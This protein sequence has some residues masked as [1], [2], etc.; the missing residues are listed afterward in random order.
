MKKVISL[1]LLLSILGGFLSN[2]TLIVRADETTKS[3]DGA[4]LKNAAI[5]T[6]LEDIDSFLL[7]YEN[8]ADNFDYYAFMGNYYS[9]SVKDFIFNDMDKVQVAEN[10]VNELS[11]NAIFNAAYVE[12]KM[13]NYINSPD[14][15]IK[16]C[17]E[18]ATFYEAILL[19]MLDSY[20]SS[21]NFIDFIS[22][23]GIKSTLSIIKSL[24]TYAETNY[25]DF[26]VSTTKIEDLTPLQQE[27]LL[28]LAKEHVDEQGYKVIGNELSY[29][30]KLI[31]TSS[32]IE[33]FSERLASYEMLQYV[34]DS[35]IEFLEL[36]KAEAAGH[37]DLTKALDNIINL[38][39]DSFTQAIFVAVED[40]MITTI[41][42]TVKEVVGAKYK[43]ILINTLT[44]GKLS[45]GAVIINGAKL[46]ISLGTTIGNLG[47]STD[48]RL[49]TYE[50]MRCLISIENLM[51]NVLTGKIA[52]Y[53]GTSKQGMLITEGIAL[54][55][56]TY[57][58]SS[59]YSLK[60]L[61]YNESDW[62]QFHS[63]EEQQAAK[64]GIAS[65]KKYFSDHFEALN[66][67]VYTC[68]ENTYAILLPDESFLICGFGV[69]NDYTLTE[70]PWKAQKDKIKKI[71][72]SSGI[73]Q[74]G[75]NIL[76]NLI[77]A[78]DYIVCKSD[79]ICNSNCMDN[80]CASVIFCRNASFSGNH[81]LCNRIFVQGSFYCKYSTKSDITVQKGACIKVKGNVEFCTQCPNW[82]WSGDSYIRVGEEAEVEVK[83]DFLLQGSDAFGHGHYANLYINGCVSIGGSLITNYSAYRI[84]STCSSGCL[85]IGKNAEMHVWSYSNKDYGKFTAGKIEIQGNY[86]ADA[87]GLSYTGT[88]EVYLTGNQEQQI[89]NLKTNSLIISNNV[90]VKYLSD[91]YVNKMFDT[92]GNPI[93]NNGFVTMVDSQ[94]EFIEG[95]DYKKFVGSRV[96]A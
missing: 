91:I 94:T 12:W 71:Y 68:G 61:E 4:E 10:F 49:D 84:V 38:C 21:D 80:T 6:D 43:D 72:I 74:L 67:F 28:D 14:E 19:K 95:Y 73:T 48:K 8:K 30:S 7:N 2:G 46:A 22:K 53:D 32:T 55:Y 82:L 39:S 34:A 17:L 25:Y 78:E 9:C 83:G 81:Q 27:V 93:D 63:S 33:K 5:V 23:K 96:F 40:G 52:E 86:N 58:L 90:G 60:M 85:K 54:L 24:A 35:T 11:S 79:V 47:F 87:D 76:S 69:T 29:I 66:S 56:K 31:S 36:M 77:N 50:Y 20:Y 88:S 1:L 42:L 62:I 3:Y 45:S 44:S 16:D 51:K 57:L 65:E 13:A 37:E 70:I 59:D 75:S 15:A 26:L 18:E 64:D 41:K 92:K 89:R